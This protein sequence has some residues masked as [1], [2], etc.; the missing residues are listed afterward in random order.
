MDIAFN[1]NEDAMK[2]AWSRIKQQLE[3]NT[4]AAGKKP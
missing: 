4:K 2:L 3:K 1:K